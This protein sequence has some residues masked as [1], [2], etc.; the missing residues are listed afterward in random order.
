MSS[1]EYNVLPLASQ[2]AMDFAMD[3][4]AGKPRYLLYVSSIH[5]MLLPIWL[6]MYHIYSAFCWLRACYL[7]ESHWFL[8]RCPQT[9]CQRH[10]LLGSS[11]GHRVRLA[12]TADYATPPE[13]DYLHDMADTRL[14]SSLSFEKFSRTTQLYKTPYSKMGEVELWLARKRLPSTS[15]GLFRGHVLQ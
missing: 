8:D 7:S 1:S 4:D 11:M 3:S 13:M 6:L 15:I 5:L 10:I 2:V 9:H 14:Y 12:T